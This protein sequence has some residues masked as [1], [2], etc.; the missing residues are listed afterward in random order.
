MLRSV[1][2]MSEHLK[3]LNWKY[4][5]A[6]G[7]GGSQDVAS[8]VSNPMLVCLQDTKSNVIIHRAEIL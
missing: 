7:S 8:F 3:I 2:Q 1:S 6:S 5:R 4:A